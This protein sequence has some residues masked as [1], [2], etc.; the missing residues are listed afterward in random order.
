MKKEGVCCNACVA[1]KYGNKIRM[2]PF[3]RVDYC[4]MAGIVT[5]AAR[6]AT[7]TSV[8]NDGNERVGVIVWGGNPREKKV[9]PKNLISALI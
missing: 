9:A 1:E 5:R 4:G 8:S 6:R 2:N 7:S 3:V